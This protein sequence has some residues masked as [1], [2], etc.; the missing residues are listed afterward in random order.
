[1]NGISILI[2]TNVLWKPSLRDQL[3]RKI[4]QGA[5]QVYVPTLVHAERIRQIA[6]EKGEDF[7][8]H[9]I[10]QLVKE[11]RFELLPFDVK[12]AETVADVWL[13]FKSQGASDNDWKEHRFDILLCAIA[14][15]RGYV[16]VT[17]DTGKHFESVP[18]RMNIAD[19]QNWFEQ[20]NQRPTL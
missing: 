5:L 14:R 7:A 17:D 8:I 20:Q 2:D 13:E 12:D 19:L 9:V 1:M 11:S 18:S 10:Q 16:L 6:D 3:T 4:K 15:S